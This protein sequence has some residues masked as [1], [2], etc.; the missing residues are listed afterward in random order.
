[1]CGRAGIPPSNRPR[2]VTV[3]DTP[4]VR[5][6]WTNFWDGLRLPTGVALLWLPLRSAEEFG[7]VVKELLYAIIHDLHGVMRQLEVSM[8]D[9]FRDFL[10][11][12]ADPV[13][14]QSLRIS[15]AL[16]VL[17]D[18]L[19][20]LEDSDYPGDLDQFVKRIQTTAAPGTVRR[21][22]KLAQLVLPMNVLFENAKSVQRADFTHEAIGLAPLAR[23][24]F[25][26][27][28]SDRIRSRVREELRLLARDPE[29][30]RMFDVYQDRRVDVALR[31]LEPSWFRSPYV[32]AEQTLRRAT[33]YGLR[34]Q[35]GRRLHTSLVQGDV[36][37]MDPLLPPDDAKGH[38]LHV[39]V[40]CLDFRLLSPMVQRVILPRYGSSL[41]IGLVVV[42]PESTRVRGLP[43]PAAR[44]PVGT[45]LR[46]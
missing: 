27:A 39:A 22:E 37:P 28:E 10:R 7:R 25:H 14:V 15:D 5:R 21:L 31:R 19:T 4:G 32:L 36:P 40:Y 33:R 34:V 9:P 38:V 13:S 29:A 8:P 42:T 30:Q 6:G 23:V 12:V 16:E 24:L 44:S 35:I 11:V 26:K 18:E 3:L 20:D 41:P 17:V 1:L 43:D 2:L 45:R 46:L